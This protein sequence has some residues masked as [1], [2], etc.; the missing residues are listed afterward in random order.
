MFVA[1]LAIALTS[2]P[3]PAISLARAEGAAVEAPTM[4]CVDELGLPCLKKET[5]AS[6]KKTREFVIQK[7][8]TFFIT[9]FLGI[10]AVTA[11][12]FIIVGG[13]QMHAAFGNE[14]MI[15]K[16]KTTITW[17][18]VGLV[19]AILSVAIVQ[20]ISNINF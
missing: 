6:G 2:A 5:Q 15:K 18:I 10:C 20:I 3:A 13:M 4:P 8:G 17:A 14:E 12:I 1:A 19:I 16:G 7:F 9:G 11:V